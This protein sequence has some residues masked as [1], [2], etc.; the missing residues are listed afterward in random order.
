MYKYTLCFIKQ[1]DHVLLLNREYAPAK[2][3]W[4]GVGGKIEDSETP[5]Q[6]VAREAYEETG[7]T[8]TN[9]KYKGVVTWIAD[10]VHSGGMYVFL[11]ELPQ[12]KLLPTPV[13]TEEGILDW[14][15]IDWILA[16]GNL[17]VGEM[18]PHF[19]PA[20]LNSEACLEHRCTLSHNKLI[21]YQTKVRCHDE[22]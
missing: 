4:N 3:L 9:I 13:K 5:L 19:L 18:I 8:L 2:G 7:L 22:N 10:E 21:D 1:N 11:V 15:P 6:C 14:K 16:E 12:D 17:G 20:V